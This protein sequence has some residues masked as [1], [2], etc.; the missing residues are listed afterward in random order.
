[1]ADN[2]EDIK[3]REEYEQYIKWWST[4]LAELLLWSDT[5]VAEWIR[6]RR[7][8]DARL[9]FLS[10]VLHETPAYYIVDE[11]IPDSLSE[12][13][14]ARDAESY[15]QFAGRVE[16]AI[17]DHRNLAFYADAETDWASCRDRVNAVLG[18]FG[19]SLPSPHNH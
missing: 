17:E 15:A 12:E 3:D 2:A 11:L 4:A 1:M 18:E 14:A 9:F 8:R 16:L 6:D 13:I 19:N 5:E 7:S 10:S